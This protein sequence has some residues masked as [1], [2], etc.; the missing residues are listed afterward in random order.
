M[1]SRAAADPGEADG[2]PEG[3]SSPT[4]ALWL[5]DKPAG[6]TS[7]DIVAGVRRR[8]GGRRVKVGHAGTLDPFA[9]GLLVVLSGRATRLAPHLSGL[10]KRYLATVRLGAVSETLDPEGPITPTGAPVPAPEAVAAALPELTGPQRQRVPGLAAVR[11]DG[12]RL[13]RLTRRGEEPE[14][15][16][17]DVVVHG[18]ALVDVPGRDEVILDV[19]CSKGTYVRRLAADLGRI[20]GCG[21][22]CAALRR[23]AVGHLRIADAVGPEDVVAGGGRPPLEAVAHLPA[24]EL[25]DAE[26]GLVRHGRPVDGA[27]EGPVA[28]THGG[29]LVAIARG[30]GATLRPSVVLV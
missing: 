28:L 18:L 30:D 20:L 5:I 2:M 25:D 4:G 1:G 21:A 8:L 15:P 3:A 9:T 24:H 11:V 12:E 13:Y 7:H 22:Y 19:H 17:R 29:H 10:D 27:G 26:L 23:T 16:E 14:L 6:P